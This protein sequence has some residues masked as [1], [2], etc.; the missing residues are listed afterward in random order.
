MAKCQIHWSSFYSDSAFST[1]SFLLLSCVE[2]EAELSMGK[3]FK[4]VFQGFY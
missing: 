3:A 1:H 4:S 2:P